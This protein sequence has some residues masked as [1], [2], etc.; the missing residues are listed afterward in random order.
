MRA[1]MAEPFSPA[2]PADAEW[3]PG[4]GGTRALRIHPAAGDPPTLILRLA[5]GGERGIEAGPAEFTIPPALDGP[6][7]CRRWPAGPRVAP[8][9]PPGPDAEVIPRRP[10]RPAHDEP[11]PPPAAPAV[12]RAAPRQADPP[13][14]AAPA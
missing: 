14:P 12:A 13:P 8:P 5:G 1:Q 2:S 9:L 11:T 4:P 10:R 6:A 7:A 3:L